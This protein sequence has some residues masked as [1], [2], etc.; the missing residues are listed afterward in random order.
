MLVQKIRDQEETIK[1]LREYQEGLE[2]KILAD[3]DEIEKEGE[4]K[5][6][7]GKLE[8][9]IAQQREYQEGLE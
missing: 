2:E 1:H 9:Q 6:S 4:L 7:I 8:A 5:K 3:H